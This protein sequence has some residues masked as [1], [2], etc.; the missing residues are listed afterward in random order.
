MYFSD[1]IS[2]ISITCEKDKTGNMIPKSES[3][4]TV[5]CDILSVSER[6]FYDAARSGMRPSVKAVVH[7]G[8]YQGESVVEISGRRYAVLRNYQDGEKTELYLEVKTGAQKSAGR[9]NGG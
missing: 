4:R 2:L 3:S 6:E 7:T 5:Y 9:T 8:E 1:K